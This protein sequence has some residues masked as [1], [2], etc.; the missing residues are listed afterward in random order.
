MSII[1]VYVF[2]IMGLAHPT[3]S[4]QH[5]EDACRF[6]ASYN[7]HPAGADHRLVIVSNGGP[8]SVE[9]RALTDQ[10]EHPVEWFI[11]DNR[12]WDIGAF[13]AAAHNFTC[14]MMVFLGTTAYL[15]GSGW[16]RRMAEAF[17]R[18]GKAAIYGSTANCG[19]DAYHV[20]PHIRTTG[21][22]LAP[23]LMN[24]Y[25]VRVT[26][27]SQRYPVEHGPNCLTQWCRNQGYKAL[28]VTWGGEY[29]WP[30]WD[31]VPNGFQ[32]GDQSNLLVGD[33]LTAPPY[34]H[35]A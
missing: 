34:Y 17:D 14:D 23:L 5:Y 9:M 30:A 25:P 10:L 28:M 4:S 1:V 29:E 15:R 2:P 8:P 24:M 31:H 22:F 27:P 11:H 6:V 13:Q 20:Y 35:T 32:R 12:G 19:N 3:H 7:Q 21:F 26:D 18:H 33:R 16:L